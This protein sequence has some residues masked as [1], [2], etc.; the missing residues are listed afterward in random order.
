MGL[1]QI[2]DNC[3]QTHLSLCTINLL[4]RDYDGNSSD[5]RIK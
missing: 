3:Q 1:L 2:S 4:G 5:R